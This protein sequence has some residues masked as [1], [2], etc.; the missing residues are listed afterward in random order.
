MCARRH[1]GA[2][3]CV[4]TSGD[5]YKQGRE[6]KSA[7]V[8]AQREVPASSAECVHVSGRVSRGEV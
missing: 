8:S 7:E 3:T 4:Q 1:K 6:C 5:V 2:S